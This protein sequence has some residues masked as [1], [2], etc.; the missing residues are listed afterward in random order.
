MDELAQTRELV[1]SA[2][3]RLRELGGLEAASSQLLG[4]LQSS[5]RQKLGAEAERATLLAEASQQ[6]RAL[7]ELVGRLRALGSADDAAVGAALEPL[8]AL[9]ERKS[10]GS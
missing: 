3:Q 4:R 6:A 5:L 7:G 9:L 8:S 10:D 2:L 1:A